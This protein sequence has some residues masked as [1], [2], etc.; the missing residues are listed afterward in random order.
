MQHHVLLHDLTFKQ[1][2]QNP[3]MSAHETIRSEPVNVGS[4][5]RAHISSET[6]ASRSLPT[7]RTLPSKNCTSPSAC[8]HRLSE[9]KPAACCHDSRTSA[10]SQV[11]ELVI[12][13]VT[14]LEQSG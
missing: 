1:Y 3:L 11:H 10:S 6:W 5:D 9:S 7:P 14:L 2:A 12:R 8:E 4:R 13:A